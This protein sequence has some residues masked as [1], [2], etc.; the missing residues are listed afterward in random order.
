MN[1]NIIIIFF[2]SS[3]LC[4]S[5]IVLLYLHFDR[6]GIFFKKNVIKKVIKEK[7]KKDVIADSQ[8]WK[9]A[10][11]NAIMLSQ[12]Q[13]TNQNDDYFAICINCSSKYNCVKSECLV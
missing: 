7:I 6:L 10:T 12:F 3:V 11:C 5:L 13:I 8:K 1:V 2:A 4:V 9:C